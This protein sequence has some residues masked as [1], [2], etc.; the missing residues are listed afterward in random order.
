MWSLLPGP[1]S[2]PVTGKTSQAAIRRLRS[3]AMGGEWD[4]CLWMG[5]RGSGRTYLLRVEAASLTISASK[6]SV[7]VLV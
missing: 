1:L 3:P 6:S 4:G 2:F 7:F 5:S